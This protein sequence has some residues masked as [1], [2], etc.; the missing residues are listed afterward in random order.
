MRTFWT[1]IL[2]IS[3][4]LF[5]LIVPA[6]AMAQEESPTPTSTPPVLSIYT[7]YP[8]QVIG[9][10]ETSSLD[11]NL[12]AG[13]EAQAVELEIEGLPE[14]WTATFRGGGEII[15]SVYV[16]RGE[17]T[18]IDLRIETPANG[19]P[20]TVNLTVIGRSDLATVEVPIE[21][22]VQEKLP[23]SL[24]FEAELPTLRGNPTTTFRFSTT[25]KNEGEEDLTVNLVAQAPSFFT[26]SFRLSGQ[27]V[28]SVPLS[29]NESKTVSIEAQPFSNV[30][31]GSYPIT[32]LAQG[33]EAE[34]V[35][36]LAAVVTGQPDLEVTA[37]D[38]RLS[39]Q[40]NASRETPIRVI[41]RNT[42]SAP[43]H[44]IKLS[45]SAPNGWTV[46]F[47]PE[48]V[49]EIPLGAEV[50]VTAKIRPADQAVAGDYVVT[51]RA[52]PGEGASQSA[53]FRIT[54]VTSTLWGIVGVGLVA[55]ALGVVALAVMRF[56]R[57]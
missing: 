17:E 57:R 50:E 42:G 8:S 16:K 45:S 27:D 44:D 18:S 30:P 21:L 14:G 40:V 3:L 4:A 15:H 56:G 13:E 19:E 51:V 28:T 49:P 34:A 43:A 47:E 7:P 55:V 53:D 31:A 5:V 9:L 25:L 12:E 11:I 32:V 46:T 23:P 54:V 1:F 48:L 37:P 52:Q 24:T 2:L 39:A 20:G 38:G 10:G 22:I 6:P 26:V 33:G 36:E 35:L 41:V 29:A